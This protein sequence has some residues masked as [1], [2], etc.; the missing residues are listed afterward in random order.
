MLYRARRVIRMGLFSF[1]RKK[2]KK[3]D[4]Q[5]KKTEDESKMP[6]KIVNGQLVKL[7]ASGSPIEPIAPQMPQAQMPPVPQP[8]P[9]E[10]P[11]ILPKLT[12]R[13]QEA[14]QARYAA[15][16]PQNQ[17]QM[18]PGFIVRIL[19][20]EGR[21]AA[22]RVNGEDLQSFLNTLNE[23]IVSKIIFEINNRVVN[24]EYILEYIVG[25]ENA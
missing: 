23:A 24:A 4:E 13:H 7:D 6:F 2:P 15:Q 22:I 5:E 12:P 8:L 11:D 10:V 25:E 19:M 17:S 18:T 1:L 9:Q 20:S 3:E 14:S 16:Q 21:D